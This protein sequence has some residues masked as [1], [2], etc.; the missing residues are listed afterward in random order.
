MYL[1]NKYAKWL[2]KNDKYKIKLLSLA[3]LLHDISH[4]PWSHSWDST[5]YSKIY[6]GIEK[7]HDIHRYKIVREMLKEQLN[8]ININP[9][10]IINV[11]DGKYKIMS[12]IIKGALSVDRMDFVNRD[13]FY[14]GA[15][16][17][18]TFEID[19]IIYNTS[20]K[21]NVLIYDE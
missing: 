5:V 12:A 19:R 16:H 4:G 11:W 14:T 9:E 18:G 17:F 1:A 21:N 3:G 15:S 20:I 7:G 8:E 2:F 13:T 10:D 6:P